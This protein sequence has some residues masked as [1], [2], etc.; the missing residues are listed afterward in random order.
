M[1]RTSLTFVLAAGL[2]AGC[3]SLVRGQAPLPGQAVA[4]ST[5]N[6]TVKLKPQE[7]RLTIQFSEKGPTL[8]EVLG[9]LKTR[10]DAARLQ[11]SR[12]AAAKESIQ[13]SEPTLAADDSQRELQ[14]RQMMAMRSARGGRLP[15][16]LE[17]PKTVTVAATLTASWPLA[18][19]GAEEVLHFSH[20]LQTKIEE[21]DLAGL[22]EKKELSP[23]EEE[24]AEEAQA[25]M[26]YAGGGEATPGQPQFLFV[27]RITDEQRDQATRAAFEKAKAQAQRL[28]KAAG[29]ELGNL[30]SISSQLTQLSADSDYSS[31]A[32]AIQMWR[33]AQ[34]A[35][36]P[37]DE[38]QEA[39]STTPGEISVQIVVQTAFA[40]K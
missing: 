22:K 38:E 40:L 27:G 10:C 7:L 18:G 37:V 28:A 24:L 26:G 9:K 14:M 35:G 3:V 13:V 33:Q 15:K 6:E 5:G 11:V 34:F 4:S 19:K 32:A 16:G 21:A 30:A 2:L 39:A 36:G 31:Y 12:L 1:S 29:A 20:D 25:L 23:E 8:K 17:T